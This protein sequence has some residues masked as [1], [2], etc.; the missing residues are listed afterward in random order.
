MGGVAA[1]VSWFPSHQDGYNTFFWIGG[2]LGIVSYA[3]FV[4]MVHPRFEELDIRPFCG[5]RCQCT[6]RCG[7]RGCER[8]GCER[9]P[10]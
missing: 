6:R 10:F 3:M 5:T 1:A 4:F 7:R 2:S 9:S 8:R